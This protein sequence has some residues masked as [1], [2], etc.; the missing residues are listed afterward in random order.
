[1]EAGRD[2]TSE[3]IAKGHPFVMKF[4]AERLMS[5]RDKV[6]TEKRI[7]QMAALT[8]GDEIAISTLP[9]EAFV[10]FTRKIRGA[11]KYPMTIV[12]ALAQGEIGYV[13]MPHNYGNGGY[14]TSPCNTVADRNLGPKF[15]EK[16]ISLLK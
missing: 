10:E 3:D 9:C 1:M 6:I 15:V 7:E 11:S 14:E 5:C 13:A 4:F 16:A 8:F 2:F 12:A